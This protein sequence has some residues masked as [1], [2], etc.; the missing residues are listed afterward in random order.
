MGRLFNDR[1][2]LLMSVAFHAGLCAQD[3]RSIHLPYIIGTG[4]MDLRGCCRRSE[5]LTQA[6]IDG[7]KP[8]LADADIAPEPEL[9]RINRLIE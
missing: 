4:G 8:R 5:L 7:R 2:P 1:L 3:W 6:G 9:L